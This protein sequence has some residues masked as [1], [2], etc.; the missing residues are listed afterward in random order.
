MTQPA[1]FT[2][3]ERKNVLDLVKMDPHQQAQ[4]TERLQEDPTIQGLFPAITKIKNFEVRTIKDDEMAGDYSERMIQAQNVV[5]MLDEI[6]KDKKGPFLLA[7]NAID[8]FFKTLTDPVAEYKG[9]RVVGG[10]LKEIKEALA[11]WT[12][13]QEKIR[14]EREAKERK[15]QEEARRKAEEQGKQY[16]PPPIITPTQPKTT[17][18]ASGS[19]HTR[20]ETDVEVKDMQALAKAVGAGKIP[21]GVFSVNKGTLINLAKAGMDLPG[22]EVKKTM[23]PVGRRRR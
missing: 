23:V 3:E 14:Q 19:V 17:K 10:K 9:S 2:H 8:A 12:A 16:I 13:K 18:T 6:R 15:R 4:L 20:E 22:C 21:V 1:E 7:C 11:T 5:K